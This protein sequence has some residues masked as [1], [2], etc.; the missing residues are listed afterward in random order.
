MSL[1]RTIWICGHRKSGTTL[2]S[3]LFDDHPLIASYG[4]DLKLI[5]AV[6]DAFD[7]LEISEIK[8]RIE[9]LFLDDRIETEN[10][11]L[12]HMVDALNSCLITD[13]MDIF[14]LIG[15]LNELL[16]NYGRPLFKET[17][18]EMY[19]NRIME[20]TTDTQFLHLV[21]DPRDN[22]AAIAAGVSKYYA[23]FGEGRFE[24][25]A[26]LI[27]RVEIGF[28]ALKLN[29]ILYKEY[30][31]IKFED[32]V[33]QPFESVQTIC[34]LLDLPCWDG[35]LTPTKSGKKYSGNSHEGKIFNSIS[36]ENVNRWQHRISELDAQIIEA[37]CADMMAYFGYE[38][39]FSDK[40]HGR[41]L[42]HF[43]GNYNQRYFFYD[44][45]GDI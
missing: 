26:S 30:H 34:E 6:Y 29:K 37:C 7:K 17:S 32:L 5:Y 16:S 42:E 41:A 3:N 28:K 18:S 13:K 2:L 39:F 45:L 12:S 15:K 23:N 21:R 38:R 25:L 9:T 14:R 31:I 1:N 35:M 22:F 10:L 19:T 36:T 11:N 20:V 8:N 27:N 43:Y 40:E 4:A 44:K 33:L 24:S